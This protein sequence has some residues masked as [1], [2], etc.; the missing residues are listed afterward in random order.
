M[1]G[2]LRALLTHLIDYAGL[3]P[4]ASLPLDVALRSYVADRQGP[5][6]WMLGRFICPATRLGE[7]AELLPAV[8]HHTPLP[9]AALGRKS[10]RAGFS[11]AL[12]ED[13]TRVAAARASGGSALVIDVLELP[14]PPGP[15]ALDTL[16]GLAGA[17]SEAGLAAFCEVSAPLDGEWERAILQALDALAAHNEAG[18]PPLALKL[19]MG[20]VTADAFPSPAQVATA[21]VG[22]RDAGV[23]LKC[24]AGLHHPFR[25]WRAEVDNHM[26]G[27]VNLFAAG[28][29][30]HAHGLDAPAVARILADEDPAAFRFGPDA[31]AWRGLAVP[32]EEIARLRGVALIAYGSCSFAEPR[33]DLRAL[34]LLAPPTLPTQ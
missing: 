2:S 7:L 12:A 33:D 1:D 4:P 3:F 11:A 19:R 22:A 29:L 14:L 20:G 34:G 6:D 24:T 26:H 18:G 30:A 23:A 32:T 10:D 25:Q 5:D 21:L 27:F 8:D 13:L 28:M 15:V 9:I 31:L 17:A 16:A